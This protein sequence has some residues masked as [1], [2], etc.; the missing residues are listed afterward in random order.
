M[1]KGGKREGAGRVSKYFQDTMG[2]SI[3]WPP[4]AIHKAKQE[5]KG[6][7]LSLSEYLLIK[8]FGKKYHR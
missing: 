7:G 6:A 1:T 2:M 4:A 5:A 8:V 3:S